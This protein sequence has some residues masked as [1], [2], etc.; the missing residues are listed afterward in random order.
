MVSFLWPMGKAC[1]KPP[2][3]PL[4]P[5]GRGRG[6]CQTWH[7]S[8]HEPRNRRTHADPW[9]ARVVTTITIVLTNT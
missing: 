8:R 9:D 3:L 6:E 4:P 5:A 2:A 7:G 1:A